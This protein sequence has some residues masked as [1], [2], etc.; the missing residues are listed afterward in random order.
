LVSAAAVT[1]HFLAT[2]AAIDLMSMGGSA[3]DAAIAADAV[4]GVVAPETCGL[5]GDLFALVHQPGQHVP[6]ALNA[7]G[8]AGS[9]VSGAALREQGHSTMP[10]MDPASVTIPG[11]VDGWH[12]LAQR[13][14]RVGWSERLAPALRY[15]TSGF[16]VS[17]ELARALRARLELLSAQPIG[18]HLYPDGRPPN[19]GENLVRPDLAESLRLIAGGNRDAFYLGAPGAAISNAVG[20]LIS[21]TDLEAQQAEWVE[22]LGL[23]LFGLEGWTIPPNSQGYLTLAS[24]AVYERWF[25]RAT[26]P[27][28]RTHLQIESYRSQVADRDLVLADPEYLPQPASELVSD[29]RLSRRLDLAKRQNFRPPESA[30]GGTA[31]LCTLDQSGMGVSFIQS[32]FMGLGTSIGA[33]SAGF[34][35]QNRGAGFNLVPGHPN[36]LGPGK[37][38]LHTLSPS[39]WTQ[40]GQLHTILGTRGGDYQP[41]LLLQMAIRMFAEGDSAAE[42]QTHPRWTIEQIDDPEAPV[43]VEADTSPEVVTGLRERGHEVVIVQGV[44]GGWGPVSVIRVGE[45]IEAAADPRVGTASAE[46]L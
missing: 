45:T 27:V 32:N 17:A 22:P 37:R 8:R 2:S 4:L 26:S 42:A 1:P 43:L 38:P 30:P 44:Q 35:L 14:G 39:I 10:L 40:S 18:R 7:S 29:A 33:G 6:T 34:I 12:A 13:Y 16:P 5:G 19:L 41:Q 31:Y 3:I 11:C 15:A 24:L 36:E 23:A 28:E 25:L 9:N 21:A 20:G 46:V